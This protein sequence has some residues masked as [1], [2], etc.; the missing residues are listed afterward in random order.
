MLNTLNIIFSKSYHHI[1]NRSRII[2]FYLKICNDKDIISQLVEH[3][4]VGEEKRRNDWKR[5]CENF[6]DIFI[7]R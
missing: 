7:K 6:D 1:F 3:I 2:I 5:S 4:I